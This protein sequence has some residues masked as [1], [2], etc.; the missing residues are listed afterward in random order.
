MVGNG[1]V[2]TDT[3]AENW[4]VDILLPGVFTVILLAA[5]VHLGLSVRG[6]VQQA[7]SGFDQG[8]AI[9]AFAN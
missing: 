6:Y 9:S 7:V 2:K 8:Y 5:L 1:K 3:V 4:V